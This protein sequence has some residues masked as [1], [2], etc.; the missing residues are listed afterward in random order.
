M[1]SKLGTEENS[2]N[3]LKSILKT[4]RKQYTKWWNFRSFP[5]SVMNKKQMP[6]NTVSDSYVLEV[7][8]NATRK[9]NEI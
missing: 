7:L 2:F 3:M 8:A 5:I 9:G 1:C 4:C 6:F